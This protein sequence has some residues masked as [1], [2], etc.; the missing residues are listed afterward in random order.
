MLFI[1]AL[2]GTV[3]RVFSKIQTYLLVLCFSYGALMTTLYLHS[4]NTSIK[5]TAKLQE[6][7]TA[8]KAEALSR[9]REKIGY[10][11]DIR[12]LSALHYKIEGHSVLE[13]D[14][15]EQINDME[16]GEDCSCEPVPPQTAGTTNEQKKRIAKLS[17]NLSDD[18][19]GVLQSA[20]QSGQ[21]SVR[22]DE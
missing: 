21:G 11:Q 17:D 5:L 14:Y 1:K 2:F 15:I 13:R 18:F 12:I 10:E 19:S 6:A 8:F 3:G 4:Q 16:K 20:Y 22:K 9:A 7:E